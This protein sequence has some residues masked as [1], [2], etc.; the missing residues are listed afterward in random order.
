MGVPPISPTIPMSRDFGI[1]PEWD[2]GT[3]FDGTL[4]QAPF[5]GTLDRLGKG[6]GEIKVSWGHGPHN[7]QPIPTSPEYRDKSGMATTIR[8]ISTEPNQL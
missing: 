7:P 2:W 8:V 6:E 4:R 5:D 3:P 1:P